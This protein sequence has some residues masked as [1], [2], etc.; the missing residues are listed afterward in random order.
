V[1]RYR[2]RVRTA[3]GRELLSSVSE[4]VLPRPLAAPRWSAGT[5]APGARAQVSVRA[6]GRDGQSVLFHL[7][8]L[9]G[10][11]ERIGHASAEVHDGAASAELPLPHLPGAAGDLHRLR[12]VAVTQDGQE[13]ISDEARLEPAAAAGPALSAAAFG[14][15]AYREGEQAALRV[16]A[17]GL[18]GEEVR[19][20]VERREGAG[21][22]RLVAEA[23]GA[24]EGGLARAQA[25]IPVAKAQARAAPADPAAA[26]L[27]FR[28]LCGFLTAQ[29]EEV[30]LSLAPIERLRNAGWAGAVRGQGASFTHG[31]Q[32]RMRV[33]A[34]GLDGRTV[35]FVVE[36][37]LGD[38]WVH[39]GV[40]TGVVA[41]GAAQA[42][43]PAAHPLV[44]SGGPVPLGALRSA[45][46]LPLR[47]RCELLPEAVGRAPEAQ[48]A[49]V[50]SEG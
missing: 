45:A 37:R 42:Q 36:Q 31:E 33:E 9:S 15:G 44:S 1:Q 27:R 10:T 47:F 35:R 21:P 7:E 18:D 46:R 13:L 22:F 23:R 34:P 5:F 4:L 3:E 49:A 39:Y 17:T 26:A 2:F 28:A 30:P 14:H 19:F 8:R 50:E 24:I 40:T 11:W 12:F 20:L 6:S 43:V 16:E 25:A 32:A 38:R 41:Q 29:S 48:S